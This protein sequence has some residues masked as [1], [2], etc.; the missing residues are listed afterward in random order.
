MGEELKWVKG[1][2]VREIDGRTLYSFTASRGASS[3]DVYAHDLE[4]A[5]RKLREEAEGKR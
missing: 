4:E 2:A 3:T 1:S 5:Q